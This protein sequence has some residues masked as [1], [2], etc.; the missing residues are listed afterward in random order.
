MRKII[1]LFLALCAFFTA[2]RKD[3]S[4]SSWDAHEITPLL[5]SSMS[6][7]DLM[8][9]DLAQKNNDNSVSVVYKQLMYSANT[10]SMLRFRDTTFVYGASLSTLIL[11]DD[12]VVHPITLGSIARGQGFLG[13]VILASHGNMATFPAL[14]NISSSNISIDGGAFFETMDVQ[15]GFMDITI[16]NGL[17]VDITTLD[18][19][20]SNEVGMT[21]IVS[22]SFPPIPAGTS[23]LMSFVLDGKTVNSK[24]LGKITTLNTATSPGDVLVDTNNAVTTVIKIRD[25]KPK[26]ATAFFP[27]QDVF[28][29]TQG[30]MLG[31]GGK[32]MLSEM[33]VKEGSVNVEF[34]SSINDTIFFSYKIPSASI[35]GVPFQIDT[36]VPPAPIGEKVSLIYSYPFKGYDLNMRGFGIENQLNV[37]LN[38]NGHLDADTVNTIVQQLVGKIKSKNQM[39]TLALGDTFYVNAGLRG[40]VPS[41]VLGYVADETMK[42]GPSTVGMSVFDKYQSGALKMEDLNVSLEVKNGFGVK[43]KVDAQNI[44]ARNSKTGQTVVLNNAET[45]A[46]IM[47][48]KALDPFVNGDI[49][50]STKL[51]SLN[52]SNSNIKDFM[53][54]FPNQLNYQMTAQ[55]NPDLP[56][57]PYQTVLATPPNFV[58]SATGLEATMNVEIPLS[59][60]ADSLL[61]ADTMDFSLAKSDQSERLN[62]A[63]FT[64][65]V[66]NGFPFSTNITIYMLD[67]TLQKMDSLFVN[68]LIAAGTVAQVGG[69]WKV[70]E[71]TTSTIVFDVPAAKIENLFNTKKLLVLADF[72]TAQPKTDFAKIYSDYAIDFKLSGDF[73]FKVKLK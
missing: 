39:V 50:Y 53:E 55:L 69:E 61:L 29:E 1:V 42:V 33:K 64:L 31:T 12:S 15:S 17:K 22:G 58:Y 49:T 35:G 52:K 10:D 44:S 14:N 18:F 71:K 7:E 26:T 60:M 30:I 51:I 24:M 20:L 72:N 46:S 28:N 37:D 48:D 41:Y 40:I 70:S 63:K 13:M 47:L 8:G 6:I 38:Q 45:S 19:L 32:M 3:L 34:F 54:I 43:L 9:S 11:T 66:E 27:D 56:S 73:D 16:R 65:I 67:A 23:Q 68:G 21:T 5:H 4:S 2:C 59:L 36:F 25:L 62:S 57:I